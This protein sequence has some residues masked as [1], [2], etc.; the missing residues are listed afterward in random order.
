MSK[1]EE[2]AR[3]R[4]FTPA[5]KKGFKIESALFFGLVLSLHLSQIAISPARGS[6][7]Q[8]RRC[9]CP[10]RRQP[11]RIRWAASP[12][13]R[14]QKRASMSMSR[15]SGMSSPSAASA[16]MPRGPPQPRRRPLRPSRTCRRSRASASM[17]C[18]FSWARVA[19]ERRRRSAGGR[20][21]R[22][23]HRRRSPRPFSSSSLSLAKAALAR[24][25]RWDLS[26][27]L[28][29]RGLALIHRGAERSEKGGRVPQARG[30]ELEE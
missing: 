6:R 8:P 23:H 12:R 20:R 27:E 28:H 16:A 26:S 13:Q 10:R 2:K 5:V 24:A 29:A 25:R 30:G 1:E 4:R 17:W 22:L 21:W 11:G 15:S 14:Y 3:R 9:P 19:E 7:G 18:P